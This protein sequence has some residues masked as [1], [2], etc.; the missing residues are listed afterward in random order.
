M[1]KCNPEVI[2]HLLKRI[3]C[4]RNVLRN[5][6]CHLAEALNEYERKLLRRLLSMR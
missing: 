2:D 1:Q 3:T 5:V 6:L 4:F